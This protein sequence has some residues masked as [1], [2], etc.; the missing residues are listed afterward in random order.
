MRR[1]H[2]TLGRPAIGTTSAPSAASGDAWA[3]NVGF[4]SPLPFARPAVHG[5]GDL[6]RHRAMSRTLLGLLALALSPAAAGAGESPEALGLT[7]APA[8]LAFHGSGLAAVRLRNPGRKAVAV[9]V[10]S[11]GFALDLPGRPHIVKR[12]GPGSAA[13]SLRLRP[14]RVRLAPHA[15]AKLIVSVRLPRRG[16]LA[17]P[18]AEASPRRSASRP[19]A[20]P[21]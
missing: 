12:R 6:H 18:D 8:R 1:C 4:T 10:S 16:L 13:G 9:T 5:R 17:P 20:A 7:A 15:A 14:V 3:T 11:P 21:A 19:H 2:R